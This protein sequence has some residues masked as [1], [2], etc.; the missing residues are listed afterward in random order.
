MAALIFNMANFESNM[1]RI[2]GQVA[3][4]LPKAVMEGGSKLLTFT[5][6]DVPLDK[7]DLRGGGGTHL[8]ETN[9]SYA[10]ASVQFNQYAAHNMFN[11]ARKQHDEQLNHPKGGKDHYLSD[12]VDNKA[13]LI[14]ETMTRTVRQ[15]L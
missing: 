12:N 5:K 11:Y 10:S 6:P 3:G 4:Q 7:G 13:S 15:V 1:R 8:T 9:M 14:I 2:Q